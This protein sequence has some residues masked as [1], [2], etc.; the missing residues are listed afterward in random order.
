MM[1]YF[2]TF[3]IKSNYFIQSE[4]DI[5]VDNFLHGFNKEFPIFLDEFREGR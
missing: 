4:C 1:D 3:E 5:S 2:D